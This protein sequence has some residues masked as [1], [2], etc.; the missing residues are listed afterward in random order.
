[1][2]KDEIDID[3]TLKLKP[4]K[5]E[6][7]LKAWI[8]SQGYELTGK[9]RFQCGEPS[10][11][12]QMDGQAFANEAVVEYYEAPIGIKRRPQPSMDPYDR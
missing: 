3:A 11:S 9:G 5:I 6:A 1:M 4:A 10:G 12:H 8:E 2:A 7:I